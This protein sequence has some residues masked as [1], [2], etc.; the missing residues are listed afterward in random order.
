MALKTADGRWIDS[1]GDAIPTKYVDPVDKLRDRVVG[2]LARRAETLSGQIAAFKQLVFDDVE[3]YIEDVA[4]K[5]GIDERTE[6]GNKV[7]TDFSNTV[8]LEIKVNKY[9]DFDE[10]LALAKEM[11]DRCIERWVAGSADQIEILIRDAFKVDQKGKLDKDR[12]LG[13]RRLKIKDAE[14]KKA[15]DLIADSIRVVGK[16]AYVRVMVK[17]DKG[18]WRTVPL[19]IA[20]C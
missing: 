7:L 3:K 8:K 4:R 9:I 15:M 20:S 6:V 17:D 10:R 13:L 19:D 14:W 1:Q 16:R 12:V 5:Y 11:I 18:V 2:K